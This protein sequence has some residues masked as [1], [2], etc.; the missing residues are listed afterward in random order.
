MA[1]E[2]HL[3]GNLEKGKNTCINNNF[4]L[5]FSCAHFYCFSL[6]KGRVLIFRLKNTKMTN[7]ARQQ[8]GQ[9]IRENIGI[10]FPLSLF[11]IHPIWQQKARA[12]LYL[13][14]IRPYKRNPISAEATLFPIYDWIDDRIKA[15]IRRIMKRN[16]NK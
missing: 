1:R 15:E 9:L 11:L 7:K 16:E 14:Q 3:T 6:V 12:L 10:V 4:V 8:L 2:I 13:C 5:L